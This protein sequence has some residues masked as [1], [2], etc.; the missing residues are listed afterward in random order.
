MHTVF[1]LSDL[2][3]LLEDLKQVTNWFQLGLRLGINHADMKR[4]EKDHK[5]DGVERC[6][7]ETIAFW[8][9][10][11][12]D[13]TLRKLVSALEGIDHRNLAKELLEIYSDVPQAGND[14][15]ILG[16]HVVASALDTHIYT[17]DCCMTLILLYALTFYQQTISAGRRYKK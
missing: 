3:R 14:I 6:K 17:S 7:A 2:R 15:V 11:S 8:L 13:V 5:H 1:I 12:E 16:P 9:K 4:I 10:N